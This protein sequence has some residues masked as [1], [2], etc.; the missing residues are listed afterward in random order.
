MNGGVDVLFDDF[1]RD[2]DGILKVVSI[3]W[4]ER[5]QDI[6]AESKLTT[7]CVG[8]ICKHITNLDLISAVA[9]R[10]LV[11]AGASIRTHELT[12]WISKDALGRIAFHGGHITEE[13]LI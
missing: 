7:F 13:L 3:P 1:F 12:Q 8:T 9:D 10:L 11:E 5:H 2:D 4:H 6:T